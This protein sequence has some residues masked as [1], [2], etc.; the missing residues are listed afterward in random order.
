MKGLACGQCYTLRTLASGDMVPLSCDCANVTGWWLDG[1]AGVARYTAEVPAYAW[2]VG[3]NN[4]F[5]V[6]ALS[7]LGDQ[8]DSY[9]REL[10]D[11]ACA[12]PGYLFDASRRNCW[13]IL[14][15]PGLVR[16]VE[17]ATNEELAAVGLPPYPAWHALAPK[18]E[19]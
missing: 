14:F 5:F 3:L 4:R 7:Q 15:K 6:A 11:Q 16:D 2:G 17:W 18:E 10:H 1:R 19:A 12:A 9:W 13:V 8:P